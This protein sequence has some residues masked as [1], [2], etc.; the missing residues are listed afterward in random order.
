[1]ENYN[2]YKTGANSIPQNSSPLREDF[3]NIRRY[4]RWVRNKWARR[5]NSNYCI[6]EVL[7]NEKYDIMKCQFV[8]KEGDVLEDDFFMSSSTPVGVDET[9]FQDGFVN[10]LGNSE[11]LLLRM[12]PLPHDWLAMFRIAAEKAAIAAGNGLEENLGNLPSVAIEVAS[13]FN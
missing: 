9:E 4:N 11:L 1:M 5:V 10:I 8:R 3:E 2:N 12:D 7:T 6:I 13:L